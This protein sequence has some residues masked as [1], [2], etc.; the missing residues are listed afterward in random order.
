[1]PAAQQISSGMLLQ[2]LQENV[3]Q[4][5]SHYSTTISYCIREL[6][7]AAGISKED[8]MRLMTL[9]CQAEG[10]A[11]ASHLR[12][13]PALQH[14][15][16][17][18]ILPLMLAA[19]KHKCGR[20]LSLLCELEA[21]QHLSSKQLAQV[22]VLIVAQPGWQP[23]AF[24]AEVRELPA[25]HFSSDQMVQMLAAAVQHDH[26]YC[27]QEILCLQAHVEL[28]YRHIVP[29]LGTAIESGHNSCAKL[30]W[31]KSCG[32]P[33]EVDRAEAMQLLMA[34]VKHVSGSRVVEFF[35]VLSAAG[36]LDSTQ[37]VQLLTSAAKNSNVEC[38]DA[39]WELP[40]SQQL[41]RG[42]V[43]GLL[44]VAS[45]QGV[46]STA[47]GERLLSLPAVAEFKSVDVVWLLNAAVDRKGAAL[48]QRLC[49]LPAAD[50]ISCD[51]AANLLH[52]AVC[53]QAAAC[54]KALCELHSAGELCGEQVSPL[55]AMAVTRKDGDC[56]SELLFL[57]EALQLGPACLVPAIKAAVADDA[58]GFVQQLCRLNAA[59]HLSGVC[60]VELMQDAVRCGSAGCLEALCQLPAAQQMSSTVVLQAFR[61]AT[62]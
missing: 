57:S 2:L 52:V 35:Q 41:G 59:Q 3:E 17:E 1:L 7:A 42:A 5:H 40:A 48:V 10:N 18:D 4:A 20:A 15:E 34:A 11:F 27:L 28:S 26:H 53:R 58:T 45:D 62:G 51:T 39:L 47:F 29:L 32:G 33:D 44:L 22:V 9:A 56:L 19:A 13:L 8:A 36:Q 31:S 6:P 37:V 24:F 23:G 38:M 12:A 25:S 50:S 43:A 16:A 14:F 49:R 46:I 60:V 55:L 30:L 21:A 61:I 54:A